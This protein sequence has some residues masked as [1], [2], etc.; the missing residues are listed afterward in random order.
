MT[1]AEARALL[2]IAGYDDL[3]GWIGAQ[4]W[5]AAPDGWRVVPLLEDWIFTVA[6]VSAARLRI[7]ALPLGGAPA[8]WLVPRKAR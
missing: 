7:T 4:P 6:S 8:A 3:D 5:T 1:K 2:L